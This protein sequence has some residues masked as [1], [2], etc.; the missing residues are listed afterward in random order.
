MLS[1]EVAPAV[2]A[3]CLAATDW[4]ASGR[5]SKQA[6]RS[7][8]INDA[9]LPLSGE[10]CVM[11]ADAKLNLNINAS[12][13]TNRIMLVVFC[14]ILSCPVLSCPVLSYPVAPSRSVPCRAT[15]LIN[16]KVGA[17]AHLYAK[18]TC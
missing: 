5:T 8:K 7:N 12:G 18:Q 1:R 13:K 2:G 3:T 9:T 10:H 16:S 11:F 14:P 15:Q 4:Q 17:S 6:N